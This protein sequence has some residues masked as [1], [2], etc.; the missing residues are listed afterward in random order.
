[1]GLENQIRK[2]MDLVVSALG[3]FQTSSFRTSKFHTLTHII[4]DLRDRGRIEY[5]HGGLY[6]KAHKIF[7]DA[8]KLTSERRG[9]AMDES[10]RQ[11]AARHSSMICIPKSGLNVQGNLTAQEAFMV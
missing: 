2:F 9:T 10:F 8:Y 6:E 4:N 11:S 3:S 5:I 1:M 7:K